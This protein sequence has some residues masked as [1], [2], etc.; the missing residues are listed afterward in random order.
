MKIK[1]KRPTKMFLKFV[2]FSKFVII[3]SIFGH[4]KQ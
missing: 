3:F 4:F 1:K 2:G